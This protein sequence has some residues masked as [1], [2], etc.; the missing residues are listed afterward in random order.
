[1]SQEDAEGGAA[2]GEALVVGAAVRQLSQEDVEVGA[3]DR[4]VC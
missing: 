1:M 3:A 2:G 4:E